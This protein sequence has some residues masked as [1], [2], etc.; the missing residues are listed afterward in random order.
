MNMHK[1]ILLVCATAVG[2]LCF[3]G[4]EGC[5]DEKSVGGDCPQGYITCDGICINPMT[6]R[7]HCGAGPNCSSN[8]GTECGP[9][10]ICDGQ[11]VPACTPDQVACNNMC[12]NPMTD[13][14]FCGATGDCLGANGGVTCL[15]GEICDGTGVCA[16]TCQDGLLNC[17]GACIDPLTD[18]NHCGA[19]GDCLDA[20]AGVVCEGGM[21]CNAGVCEVTCPADT[22]DCNGSCIDPLTDRVYCGASGDCQ[23]ANAGQRCSPGELCLLGICDLNCPL[24]Y[25]DCDGTCVDPQTDSGYCGASGNCQGANA[26]VQCAPGEDCINAACECAVTNIDCGGVCTDPMTDPNHCGA[27]GD[28]QGAN[29]GD[30]CEVTEFCDAGVCECLA[31]LTRCNNDCVDINT[32]LAHCGGCNRPCPGTCQGGICNLICASVTDPPAAA[33]TACL[34]VFSNCVDTGYAGVIG[35]VNC[36][37]CNC[38]PIPE[39]QMFC[40]ATAYDT[41]NCAECTF[42]EIQRS[43][44]PCN[45]DPGT[46]P[47][48]GTWCN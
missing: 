33:M 41:Y 6:D 15:A 13:R 38:D 9:G 10:E 24:G 20:N 22:I 43:H 3:Y 45:C 27:S 5:G 31:G 47:P 18:R 39:W 30:V 40:Y 28:C 26:G 36:Q 23:G 14:D 2:F 7:L 48:I 35:Y 4:V 11:C 16:L 44:S 46:T 37:G 1:T 21:I 8:P 34:Q 32:D 17:D 19:S 42:G 12:I 29:A 25:I